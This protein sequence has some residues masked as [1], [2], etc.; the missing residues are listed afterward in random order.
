MDRTDIQRQIKQLQALLNGGE[1][2]DR[3][4]KKS[5]CSKVTK[6]RL[7]KGTRLVITIKPH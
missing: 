4:N 3:N 2:S 6:L 7:R 5:E 1:S